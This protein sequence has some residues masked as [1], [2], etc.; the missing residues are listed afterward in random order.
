MAFEGC[1]CASRLKC[2]R[3]LGMTGAGDTTSNETGSMRR[4][5]AAEGRRLRKGVRFPFAAGLRLREER[6][7]MDRTASCCG[8]S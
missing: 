6:A 8:I 5:G 7:G 2:P 4:A 1:V 3:S